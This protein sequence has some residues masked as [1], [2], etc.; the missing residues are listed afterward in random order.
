MKVAQIAKDSDFD[1]VLLK[2]AIRVAC[3]ELIEV[4]C[5]SNAKLPSLLAIIAETILK[6]YSD[7]NCDASVLGQQAAEK[8]LEHLGRKPH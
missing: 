7:G 6:H 3:T 1:V 5:I 2:Q 4:Q 8:A